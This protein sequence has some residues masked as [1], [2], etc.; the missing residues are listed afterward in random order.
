M[1]KRS[2]RRP[3]IFCHGRNYAEE[4]SIAIAED[5]TLG[6]IDRDVDP[7]VLASD[8]EVSFVMSYQQDFSIVRRA[9]PAE[10]R[11]ALE[12]PHSPNVFLFISTGAYTREQYDSGALSSPL[13][14]DAMRNEASLKLEDMRYA[15]HALRALMMPPYNHSE[16]EE[17]LPPRHLRPFMRLFIRT[18]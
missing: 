13:L 5:A 11:M 8:R 18:L 4:L 10:I 14:P 17:L 16:R 9:A 1:K 3:S 7:Q 6:E 2:Y 12:I 15:V